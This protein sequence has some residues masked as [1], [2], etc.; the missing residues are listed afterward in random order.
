MRKYVL[1]AFL[2]TTK[3]TAMR[4]QDLKASDNSDVDFCTSSAIQ[5]SSHVIY[6]ALNTI[7]CF[8]ESS[9]TVWVYLN[10]NYYSPVCSCFNSRL[11]SK[12]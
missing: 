10:Q 6:I 11:N 7:D 9:F 1:Q 5:H 3:M 2:S 12:D 4:K 8:K